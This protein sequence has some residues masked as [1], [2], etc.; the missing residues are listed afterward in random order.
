MSGMMHPVGPQPPSVYWIRRAVVIVVLL[1]IIAAVIWLVSRLGGGTTDAAA[2]PSPSQGQT[3]GSPSVSPSASPSGSKST[4]PTKSSS[5]SNSPSQAVNCKDDQIS[6]VA[7]PDKSSYPVGAS[8]KLRMRITNS[9]SVSCLR[10]V[11]SPSNELIVNQGSNRFW[12]SDDCSPGGQADVVT[13]KPG[14]SYS[15]TLT[16]PEV[17]STAGCPSS[18]SPV[19]ATPGAYTLVGRNGQ[20][21]SAAAKFTIT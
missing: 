5:P 1:A 15:V 3:S 20:V 13:L 6:V 4:K 11:G 16:W 8:P 14:E 19:A 17:G 10:D 21:Y 12:S 7:S 9:S 2:A 18:A